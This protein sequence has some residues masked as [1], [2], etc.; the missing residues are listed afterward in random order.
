[1]GRDD[2]DRDRLRA[3]LARELGP[4]KIRRERRRVDRYT[5]PRPEVDQR[6]E[7]VLVRMGDH[8]PRN[9]RPFLLEIRD[10]GEHDVGAGRVLLLEGDAEI[11]RE[12]R[13]VAARTEAVETE[14]H[15]D[16]APPAEG[17]EDQLVLICALAHAPTVA[18]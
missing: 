3:R 13:P 11:D 16:L 6:A 14:V 5:D 1:A 18:T 2:G 9:A 15:A 17:Q 10:V 7:M 12:P 8:H 4:E